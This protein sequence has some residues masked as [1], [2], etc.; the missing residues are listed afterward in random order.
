[1]TVWGIGSLPWLKW[2][3]W[4]LLLT[5]LPWV[6]G[7]STANRERE[8]I[9]SYRAARHPAHAKAIDLRQ[10]WRHWCHSQRSKVKLLGTSQNCYAMHIFSNL[11]MHIDWP[12]SFIS[13]TTKK[14]LFVES[15]SHYKHRCIKSKNIFLYISL[16]IRHIGNCRHKCF[17]C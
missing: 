16:N 6:P 2:L 1:M 8:R 12:W 13:C 9:L 17:R 3:P 15:L 7:E 14:N 11:F 4:L 10:L 5:W